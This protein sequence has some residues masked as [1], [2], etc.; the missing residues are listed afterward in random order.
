MLNM[1]V[2]LLLV[3]Y[4]VLIPSNGKKGDKIGKAVSIL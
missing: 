4:E 3:T 2:I 1:S